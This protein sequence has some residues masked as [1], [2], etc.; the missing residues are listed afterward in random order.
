LGVAGS[1]YAHPV[2]RN[3]F[4]RNITVEIN[5]NG[6][7]VLFRVEID[8]F[9]L[10]LLVG[11]PENGFPLDFKRK[12]GRK[13]VGE[14]F[15]KR[16]KEIVPD[17]LQGTLNNKPLTFACTDARVEFLDSAQFRFR[18]KAKVKYGSGLQQFVLEDQN[19]PDKAG[20]MAI[21]LEVLPPLQV[22]SLSELTEKRT[23]GLA[24]G[25]KNEVRA[26]FH[27]EAEAITSPIPKAEP[28]PT[29]PV[30]EVAVTPPAEEQGFWQLLR[31]IN[32]TENLTLLLDSQMGLGLLLLLAFLHGVMHSVAPGHGK[33]MVAAYLVGEKG[34]P[35]HALL[36]GLI[37]TL[38]H[39]S[40]AITIALLLKYVLKDTAPQ[41]IQSILGIAGGALITF[42]GL[43]LFLQRVG[44]D[45]H[46]HSHGH[47]HSHGD[48]DEH[49]HSHGMTPEQ[50]RSFGL[51]RLVLLGI[52]GGIVPCWGAILW[53]IYCVSAGRIG[54]AVWAV[55][56]FSAGLASVLILLGLSVVWSSRLGAR[57]FGQHRWF[58]MLMRWLPI[59]GA[60]LIV[61][62]GLW[63][64]K[65]N[66]N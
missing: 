24:E 28:T 48:G 64:L 39:T 4:D 2:P 52:S 12:F 27:V 6:I 46:G 37:V 31:H 66:L 36:L 40:S 47:S 58:T 45:G 49:S 18:C 32:R 11:D 10:L 25:D 54:L 22:E 55:L 61:A 63:I 59:A 29:V 13:E 21:K 23:K 5:E 16:M 53:V 34:T 60:A 43:W 15:L 62:I 50:F 30:P 56:A 35:R 9:S 44:G 3:E 7:D 17:Y 41:T 38:T 65:A 20:R 57:R 42:I 8:E 26:S 14:A 51:T 1:A 33:T 19:F